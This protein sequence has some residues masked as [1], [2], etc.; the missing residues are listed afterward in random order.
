MIFKEGDRVRIISEDEV[1]KGIIT[2]EG[3][4][5][6]NLLFNNTM[7]EYCGLVG[8]ITL[9]RN[10]DL[11]LGGDSQRRYAIDI[12]VRYDS[13]RPWFFSGGM[14][15]LYTNDNLSKKFSHKQKFTKDLI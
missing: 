13:K 14:L 1:N 12:A 7:K 8:I 11:D 10:V 5:I 9:A 3:Y 2:S 6:D 4:Y 15:E